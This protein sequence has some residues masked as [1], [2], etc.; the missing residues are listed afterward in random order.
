M[1]TAKTVDQAAA[2][3]TFEEALARLKRDNPGV[4]LWE[5]STKFGDRWIYRAPTKF[6]VKTYRKLQRIE[7]D[8]GPDG[9]SDVAFEMLVV[10]GTNAD[11]G[12]GCVLWPAKRELQQLLLRRALLAQTMAGEI[13]EVAGLDADVTRKKL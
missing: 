10:G 12:P 2:K 5:G 9:D 4:E 7:K 8:K 13:C 3:E 1:E 6:E 11:A